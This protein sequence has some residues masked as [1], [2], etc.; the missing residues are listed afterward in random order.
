MPEPRPPSR[1]RIGIRVPGSE[2]EHPATDQVADEVA[3]PWQGSATFARNLHLE[4]AEFFRIVNRGNA[5][6]V[7]NTLA[8][9]ILVHP[10]RFEGHFPR[11][12][13]VGGQENLALLLEAIRKIGEESGGDFALVAASAEDAG[14][15][16]ELLR[17]GIG[18]RGHP[19]GA[20]SS[21]ISSVKRR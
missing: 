9:M 2:S 21:T 17:N 18:R 15:G 7:K 13:C 5:R 8:G 1:A 4:A 16:D 6:E 19:A 12:R 10:V 14:D 3:V 11:R 20:Y